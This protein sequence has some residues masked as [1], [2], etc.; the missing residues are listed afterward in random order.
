[1]LF[2]L[3]IHV[4]VL[5]EALHREQMLEGKLAALQRLVQN[6]QDASE[7]GWQVMKRLQLFCYVSIWGVMFI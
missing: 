5:Q 6:T 1:M 7:A 3:N 2:S 4:C